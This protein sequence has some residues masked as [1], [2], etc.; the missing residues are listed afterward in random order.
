MHEAATD[1]AITNE[2]EDRMKKK[3]SVYP[4]RCKALNEIFDEADSPQ[5]VLIVP[6]DVAKSDHVGRI[7]DG[8]G[9]YVYPKAFSVK[10]IN[11]GIAQLDDWIRKGMKRADVPRRRVIVALEDPPQYAI[12]FANRLSE[13]GVLVVR[14][15]ARQAS[16]KRKNRRT[17]SDVTA[18]DGICR[19]VMDREAYELGP[20]SGAFAEMRHAALSRRRLVSTETAVKNMTHRS[21]EMLFP[22]FSK[23][24]GLQTFG[25]PALALMKD[26]LYAEKID[27]MRLGTLTDKLKRRGERNPEAVAEALKAA[28]ADAPVCRGL[29]EQQSRTLRQHVE[30]LQNVRKSLELQTIE[31]GA[32]LAKTDG[33]YFTTIPGIGIPLAG[34]IVAE[35]GMLGLYGHADNAASYAG[36][37]TRIY[38][39]GGP[40]SAP[41]YGHLPMDRNERLK[42]YVMQ[43]AWHVGT[44]PLPHA[45]ELGVDAVHDLMDYY[46]RK[47]AAGEASR[48]ATA[49]KLLAVGV[50]MAR[51]KAPYQPRRLFERRAGDALFALRYVEGM[52]L[53]LRRKWMTVG[54][55]PEE[56]TDEL[57][58]LYRTLCEL[59]ETYAAGRQTILED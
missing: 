34:Q 41:K 45:S 24:P 50:S 18:L 21:L 9:N 31:L 55:K 32:A 25:E 10:N 7:C 15:S 57:G 58:R 19:M 40:S 42:D 6:I 37:V 16:G 48:L 46:A 44:T 35:L 53:A 14:V 56:N 17:S 1:D 39:T 3:L 11:K 36:I 23:I 20:E 27:R 13:L 38:Q 52:R 33:V 30:T 47:E 8:A 28:A 5:D 2:G 22:G 12:N 4:V 43:A 26:G 51:A 54:I 29:I 49:K 59:S